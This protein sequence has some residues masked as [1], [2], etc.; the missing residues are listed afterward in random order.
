MTEDE[1]KLQFATMRNEVAAATNAFYTYV[2]IHNFAAESP[3]HY[4][5]INRDA[6]F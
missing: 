2:E 6:N 3:E 4:Q 5:K 1:Y